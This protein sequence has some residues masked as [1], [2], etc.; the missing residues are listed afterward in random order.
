[1]TARLADLRSLERRARERV[2]ATMVA[3]LRPTLFDGA[4]LP[5]RAATLLAAD[6]PPNVRA[7][8]GAAAKAPR[9]GFRPSG[10][11]RAT[12]RRLAAE[13]PPAPPLDRDRGEGRRLAC[14]ALSACPT[15]RSAWLAA[16]SAEEAAAV[17][18]LEA[19]PPGA[20]TPACEVPPDVLARALPLDEPDL[21]SALGAMARGARDGGRDPWARAGREAAELWRLGCRA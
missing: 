14:A 21:T 6:A 19:L 11:L 2:L 20:D 9:P 4:A 5:A 18:A 8:W 10:S 1:V 7:A 3:R 12:L 17:L 15:L 13:P 16:L